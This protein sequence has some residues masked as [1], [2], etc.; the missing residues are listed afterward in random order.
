MPTEQKGAPVKQQ[1]ASAPN[2]K[3]NPASA[4]RPTA[5]QNHPRGG[6]S[7]PS[8]FP[9]GRKK[10][11]NPARL[12]RLRAAMLLVGS[13]ILLIGLLLVILPL[14]KLQKIEIVGNVNY[15]EEQVLEHVP[16]KVGDEMLAID[17]NATRDALLSELSYLESVT[18]RSV[19]PGTVRIELTEK[20]DVGCFQYGDSFYTFDRNFLVLEQSDTDQNWSA[21][22]KVKLPE[23]SSVQVGERLEFADADQDMSYIFSLME[24]MEKAGLLPYVTLL[25]CEQKFGNAVELNSNCRIVLGKVSSISSKLELAQQILVRKGMGD[26]QCVVLDVSDLSKSTYRLLDHE[27]FLNLS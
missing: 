27:E 10:R 11:V 9:T 19:F 21:F 1:T 12:A 17:L 8:P 3:A 2:R 15:T 6:N 4:G 23:L 22:P 13:C 25:D 7:A 24:E 18:I 5:Q 16:L 14:F 20:A 26:G